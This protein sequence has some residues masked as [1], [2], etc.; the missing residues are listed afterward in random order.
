[1]C[2]AFFFFSSEVL[3][4]TNNNANKLNITF[5]PDLY[6]LFDVYFDEF[7]VDLS[8]K[9]W[10]Q[11]ASSRLS[12]MISE[13]FGLPEMGLVY[14]QQFVMISYRRPVRRFKTCDNF[15]QLAQLNL[16]VVEKLKCMTVGIESMVIDFVTEYG[17]HYIDGYTLGD[18][19]FQVNAGRTQTE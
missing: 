3:N 9:P 15:T 5:C 7:L 1:M 19:V 6:C 10:K 2:I 18:T 16:S 8:E 11:L 13:R 12:H 14:G 4:V 17:S